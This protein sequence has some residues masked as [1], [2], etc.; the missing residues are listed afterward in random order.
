MLKGYP[1][2]GLPPG[3]RCYGNDVACHDN[4]VSVRPTNLPE[5]VLGSVGGIEPAHTA[6]VH[7]LHTTQAARQTAGQERRGQK[8]CVSPPDI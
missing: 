8:R 7:H 4:D 3:M 2:T 6:R 5:G 1:Y